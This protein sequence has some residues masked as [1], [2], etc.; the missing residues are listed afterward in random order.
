ESGESSLA[1]V[2]ADLGFAHHS[3]LTATLRRRL[4]ITPRALRV[5]LRGGTPRSLRGP[6]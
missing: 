6:R 3:H 2:A 5:Q 4:G 1:T